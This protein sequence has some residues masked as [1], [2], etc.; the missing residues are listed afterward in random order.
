M[1]ATKAASIATARASCCWTFVSIV[2]FCVAAEN[3]AIGSQ[4]FDIAILNAPLCEMNRVAMVPANQLFE[5]DAVAVF[6]NLA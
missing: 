6:R 2:V 1:A 4:D 3:E 5:V